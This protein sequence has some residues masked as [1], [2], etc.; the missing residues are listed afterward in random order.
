MKNMKEDLAKSSCYTAPIFGWNSV[1]H[2]SQIAELLGKK[3]DAVYYKCVADKMKDA[4]QKGVIQS[5]GSM[6]TELMGAYVLPIYF[7]LVP[8]ELMETFSKHLVDLIV[9]NDYCL[10]TGFLAT[11]FLMEALCKINHMDLAEKIL[12]QNKCPSWLFEVDHGAT[13]IWESWYGYKEDGNPA[14]LSF[15]HYAFGAIDAWMFKV[16]GGIDADAPG[17][18]HII[19][20]PQPLEGITSCKRTYNCV[21]GEIVCE[22]YIE[23]R[24]MHIEVHIPCNTT[25][26]VILPNGSYHEIGSGTYE[27]Q[28]DI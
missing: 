12:W 23:D 1:Q 20:R 24:H 6:P 9:K 10:D 17:F 8:K 22:W 15:N 14:D 18:K 27:F 7:D 16:I 19:I 28:S 13:T 5:D 4:I 25:S 21:Y 2:L 26:T 3:E 11:P